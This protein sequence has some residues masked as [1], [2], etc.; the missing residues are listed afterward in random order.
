MVQTKQIENSKTFVA[1]I[2][3]F[4]ELDI[5][6]LIQILIEDDVCT[7]DLFDIIYTNPKIVNCLNKIDINKIISKVTI[8]IEESENISDYI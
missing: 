5:S 4:C 2:T 7:Y 1:F 3:E 6:S 8:S